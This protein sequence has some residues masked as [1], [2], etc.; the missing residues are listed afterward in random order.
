MIYNHTTNLGTA[1]G[2]INSPQGRPTATNL[3]I[4]DQDT[5]LVDSAA[6]IVANQLIDFNSL[7]LIEGV[8]AGT[9]NNLALRV[10]GHALDYTEGNAQQISISYNNGYPS[11]TNV[12]PKTRVIIMEIL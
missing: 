5:I 10:Y 1:F 8:A 12:V 11:F 9:Y 7:D 4:S 6:E 3:G 2:T